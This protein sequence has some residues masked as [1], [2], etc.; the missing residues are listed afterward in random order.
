MSRQFDPPVKK[1]LCNFTAM[2]SC[3]AV[4][5]IRTDP[6]FATLPESVRSKFLTMCAHNDEEYIKG[7]KEAVAW[8]EDQLSQLD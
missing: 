2:A 7:M 3:Q 6:S 1:I 4:E 5:E 8:L